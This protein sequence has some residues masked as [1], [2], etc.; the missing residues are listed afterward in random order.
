MTTQ[1]IHWQ[2]QP[3]QATALARSEQE[4][5]YGGA[6]GGGKTDAGQAWLL[7][8]K[9]H[10]KFRALVIRKNADDLKDWVDRARNMYVGTGAVIVG[11]PPE[12]RFPKGGVIRTG[13]LKDENAYSKYQGH[14]YQRMLVEELSQIPREKD[15]LKLISSC[16]STVPELKPQVFCTT[17][18]DDPGLEWIKER[19]K[20]PEI[21]DFDKVYTTVTEEGRSVVF[22]PA[23]LEDNPKLMEVDPSYVQLIDSWKRT[24]YEQWEAWRLGNWK[25][26][27][28]EG[29]YYRNQL[30]KAEAD[31]RITEVPYDELLPVHTWC[32][33]GI[34]DS[35]AI[36][37][38]QIYGLQWRMIDYDEFEGESLGYAIKLMDGKG[39]FY[40]THHAPHDIEVRELGTG[41]SRY[42]IAQSLGV[43]YT[44]LPMMGVDDGINAVR[45]RFSSLWFDKVKCEQFL[46]RIRRYHKEFDEKRGVFKNKPVHDANSHAADMLRYWATTDFSEEGDVAQQTRPAW[47]SRRT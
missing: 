46:K 11:N 23:K 13:H 21:P 19:W 31:N 40:G 37:Y 41:K 45:M 12:I 42:E 43:D 7:Y 10:P 33:L 34:G 47:I 17:N 26:F 39:Y 4:I 35:F 29:A 27:G 9:D 5:L 30:I 25:G 1:N 44:V 38:F 8:D 32:D 2:P 22:I 24:D 36:G 28:V 16:R 14:E 20:I 18:P 6:R 15:Y 3:K